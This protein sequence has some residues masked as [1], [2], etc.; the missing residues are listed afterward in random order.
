MTVQL[1]TWHVITLLITLSG[2]LAAYA[3]LFL[4]RV[5]RSF[6]ESDQRLEH[7]LR[8]INDSLGKEREEIRRIDRQLLELKAELPREYVAKSD[9]VRSFTVVEAKLDSLADK[10]GNLR[11]GGGGNNG[12]Q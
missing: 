6:V 1:E 12:H 10:I 3:R 4:S 7:G 9:F 2:S 8:Q 5:E 11:N